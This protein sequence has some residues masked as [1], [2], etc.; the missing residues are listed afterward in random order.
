[1]KDTSSSHIFGL[2][3]QDADVCGLAKVFEDLSREN[4]FC[5]YNGG[6]KKDTSCLLSLV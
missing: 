2:I 4:F 5:I 1:M 3:Q 6:Q